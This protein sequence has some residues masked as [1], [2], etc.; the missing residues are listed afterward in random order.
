[1]KKKSFMLLALTALLFFVSCKKDTAVAPQ[2][3]FTSNVTEGTASSNG[4]YSITGHISSAARLLKVIL[5]IEGQATPFLTDEST[6]KNKNEYDF[7]YLV[8]GITTNTYILVD[9]YDQAGGK[10]TLRF[11]IK[12]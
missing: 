9:A 5:T 10:I 1:M 4:E 6:A 12:K 7:S 2:L 11:L 3:N 8:T